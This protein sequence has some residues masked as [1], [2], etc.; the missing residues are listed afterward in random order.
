MNPVV[1]N[2][3]RYTC[4]LPCLFIAL[5]TAHCGDNDV[6]VAV[7]AL[8]VD[9]TRSS[10]ACVVVDQVMVQQG[11]P[12]TFI[13]KLVNLR[14]SSLYHESH[15]VH[16]SISR[17]ISPGVIEEIFA[18]T[19]MAEDG[20]FSFSWTPNIHTNAVRTLY[21]LQF[22]PENKNSNTLLTLIVV[23]PNTRE[24]AM[25]CAYFTDNQHSLVVRNA[26][27]GTTTTLYTHLIGNIDLPMVVQT[28]IYGYPNHL[29]TPM[30]DLLAYTHTGHDIISQWVISPILTE[31]DEFVFF[32][33]KLLEDNAT[34]PLDTWPSNYLYVIQ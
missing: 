28:R 16:I 3:K 6:E 26:A 34:L 27:L 8:A 19:V 11:C 23:N 15:H 20:T 5:M 21:R 14:S 13:G 10:C 12:A 32:E 22:V 29:T 9:T 30:T 31:N 24:P 1:P 4:P 7:S 25:L 33:T 2:V 17:E 18:E